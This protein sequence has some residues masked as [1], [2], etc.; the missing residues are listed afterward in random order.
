MQKNSTD[1]STTHTG[2]G[3]I[4]L[5]G[6]LES[7]LIQNSLIYGNTAAAV[8]SDIGNSASGVVIENSVIGVFIP[9]LLAVPP[10][11]IT[12]NNVIEKQD[13]DLDYSG[14]ESVTNPDEVVRY[15]DN[16][17]PVK[18]GNPAFLTSLVDQLGNVRTPARWF[19]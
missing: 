1:G 17:Y 11:L 15:A 16:T 7:V 6:G 10:L 14:L 4:T 18:I 8:P 12:K 9:N 3:G 13:L 19:Y 2:G 5:R